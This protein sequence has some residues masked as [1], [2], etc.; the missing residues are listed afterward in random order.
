MNKPRTIVENAFARIHKFKILS[1]PFRGMHGEHPIIFKVV[2]NIVQFDIAECPLRSEGLEAPNRH[3]LYVDDVDEH[4][5]LP[6]PALAVVLL[7][8]QN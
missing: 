5:P 4:N 2:A 1:T 7:S 8:V 3:H 6:V